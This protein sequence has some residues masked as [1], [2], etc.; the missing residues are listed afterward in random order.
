MLIKAENIS[1]IRGKKDILKNIN[2]EIDNDDFITIIGPNGAGK[3]MLLKCLMGFF[4]PDKGKIVRSPELKVSYAPQDFVPEKSIPISAYDFI[5]LNKKVSELEIKKIS[6]EFN[7]EALLNKQISHLSGGELQ[8]VLIV[9]SLV[10][11]PNL[12][13]LDEPTQNLDVSGQL[14]FYK[15]LNDIFNERKLSILMVSHDLHMVMSS[16][17]KVICL[18]SH[19]CC[20]GEPLAITQDPEFIS[21]FGQDFA[22]MM[23]VYKHDLDHKHEGHSHA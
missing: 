22:E 18:S 1:V 12:L 2:L 9:R 21:L 15:F 5:K 16:T 23:S 6:I 11:N 7:I 14:S 4:K 19:I 13:I 3:S 20:S 8:K 17:K 10:E